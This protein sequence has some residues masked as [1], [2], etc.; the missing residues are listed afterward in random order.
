M[1]ARFEE[2]INAYVERQLESAFESALPEAE[3][4]R[5]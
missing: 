1:A 4:E 3:E 2:R 5:E